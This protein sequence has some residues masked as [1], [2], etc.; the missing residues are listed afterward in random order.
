MTTNDQSKGNL[1][2]EDFVASKYN[3]SL[4]DGIEQIGINAEDVEGA[5]GF[6][7]YD[8]GC[9]IEDHGEGNFMVVIGRDYYESTDIN[10]LEK[11]L[12]EDWYKHECCDHDEEDN[13]EESDGDVVC[14]VCERAYDGYEGM[15]LTVDHARGIEVQFCSF[16][17]LKRYTNK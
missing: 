15:T 8:C 1:S 16:Q 6:V 4:E 12:Y 10:V 14:E 3:V 17:C 13:D 11:H 7:F 5:V 2:F 9:Y